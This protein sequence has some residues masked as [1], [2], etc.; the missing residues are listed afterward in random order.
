M[1]ILRRTAGKTLYGIAKLISIL[2]GGLIVVIE[3]IVTFVIG[4]ARTF[5]IL[6]G[7]GG[8]LFLFLL[9]GP[10]GM[11]LL[12]NPVTLLLILFFIIFP[13]LGTKF[14]SYL[15]YIRYAITEYLFDRANYLIDG[16]SYQFQ[17][18]SE[19]GDR[20]RKMEEEKWRA[21]QERRRA[22]QQR[23]WEERFRQWY[24][25]QNSQRRSGGYGGQ[26]GY[27]WQ[28][29]NA[30][31]GGQQGYADPTSEFKQKYKRSCDLLGVG[32]D[33][34]KYEI[35]LAYRQKA[36]KYHPDLNKS[37]DA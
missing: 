33:A 31:Y 12:L 14:I 6:I 2:L 23:E 15:K 26:G 9:A 19:Y 25:Y 17:S 3:T 36:K 32:Y 37:P 1:N 16:A 21:E 8:C 29:Q 35:K 24:E 18:F 7:M 10:F 11:F 34:D 5:A 28:G 13:I 30:G 20:Y 27:Y 22:Q 4:V